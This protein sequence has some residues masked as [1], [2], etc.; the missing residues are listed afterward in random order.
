MDILDQI[1]PSAERRIEAPGFMNEAASGGDLLSKLLASPNATLLEKKKAKFHDEV[2][3]L[4]N[5][6]YT[7]S[8]IARFLG[9]APSRV[10]QILKVL[11][12][13][14][15]LVEETEEAE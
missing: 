7:Q 14:G 2:L 3:V 13:T 15:R 8:S 5:A 6:G 4:I 1:V 9:I 11:R 10:N 12:E